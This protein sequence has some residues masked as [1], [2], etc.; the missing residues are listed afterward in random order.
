LNLKGFLRFSTQINGEIMQNSNPLK[1]DHIFLSLKNPYFFLNLG[2][3][4]VFLEENS[5]LLSKTYNQGAMGKIFYKNIEGGFIYTRA[6]GKNLYKR[7]RGNNTQ[8]PFYLD[9]APLIQESERVRII[10]EGK[11][12]D[13]KRGMD[14][15]IDC[16]SGTITFLNRIVKE[17]EIVEVF[18]QSKEEN[19]NEIYGFRAGSKYFGYSEVNLRNRNL[20]EGVYGFDLN[21]PLKYLNL[22]FESAFDKYNSRKIG[23]YGGR[24]NFDYKDLKI[25]GYYKEFNDFYKPIESLYFKKGGKED[26]ISGKYKWF[27]FKRYDFEDI[28]RKEK[29][30]V[31]GIR[32]DKAGY[33]FSESYLEENEK[34]TFSLNSF[35]LAHS[36]SKL[37]FR[38]DYIFGK[39]KNPA[40]FSG[41]RNTYLIK[42]NIGYRRSVLNINLKSNYKIAESYK[43]YGQKGD[44]N[45]S[46][47]R[48]SFYLRSEYFKNS[49]N[50]QVFILSSGYGFYP[51]NSLKIRGFVRREYKF[52]SDSLGK[53]EIL[54]L[55]NSLDFY[56]KRNSFSPFVN[57]KE[58][59]SKRYY[60]NYISKGFNLN[61][62]P[63]KDLRALYLFSDG[64]SKG[65][66]EKKNNLSISKNMGKFL[67][68]YEYAYFLNKGKSYFDTL[69]SNAQR[70]KSNKFML[71]FINTGKG[72][73]S[74]ARISDSLWIREEQRVD[75]NT[76]TLNSK[77]SKDIKPSLSLYTGIS[78]NKKKGIDTHLSEGSLDFYTISPFTGIIGRIKNIIIVEGSFEIENS[79]K[80]NID[81]GRQSAGLILSFNYKKI[82][83]ST[84]LEYKKFLSPSYEDLRFTFNGEFRF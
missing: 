74:Y 37:K 62:L 21:L 27:Y 38:F 81:Y 70:V 73:E 36:I 11:Y 84:N 72:V 32:F 59:K 47:K 31:L 71:N 40:L 9:P 26:S 55:S 79:L 35:Y 7:F 60:F 61:L 76:I 22:G 33:E 83:I 39:E 57:F 1:E 16:F 4:K 66:K 13:L 19:L 2:D 49:L 75:Y 42:S 51:Y 43:E 23:A 20:K 65:S 8:G 12:Q 25:M 56:F 68:V 14:Y 44:V 80:R 63:Y 50:P 64:K 24:G 58:I 78:F 67:L 48:A 6:K 10:K 54:S 69:S 28:S 53:G 34:Y 46:F 52:L 18:Y 82:N 45:L 3:Q 17:D 77:F 5:L 15:E 41:R 30:Y 29:N